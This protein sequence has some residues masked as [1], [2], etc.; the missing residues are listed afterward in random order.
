[1]V[2]SAVYEREGSRAN[3]VTKRGPTTMGKQ[4]DFA[5]DL[6]NGDVVFAKMVGYPWWPGVVESERSLPADIREARPEDD[7]ENLFAV[8]F[9]GDKSYAWLPRSAITL[10]DPN[11]P[12]SAS[13]AFK[14]TKKNS[15]VRFLSGVKEAMKLWHDRKNSRGILRSSSLQSPPLPARKL[16]ECSSQFNDEHAQ[17]KSRESVNRRS[18]DVDALPV[19]RRKD[20]RTP[21]PLT[22]DRREGRLCSGI[23]S[24]VNHGETVRQPQPLQQGH[25]YSF[26]A[27]PK[28]SVR[29]AESGEVPGLRTTRRLSSNSVVDEVFSNLEV[30]GSLKV[31]AD[32]S[33][34][35]TMKFSTKRNFDNAERNSA[36]STCRTKRRIV[37]E[38]VKEPLTIKQELAVPNGET[39][40]S[41]INDLCSFHNCLFGVKAEISEISNVSDHQRKTPVPSA[42]FEEEEVVAL[43]VLVNFR[44]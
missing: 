5:E 23:S 43:S 42:A 27:S 24:V 14:S 17:I 44:H 41:Q 40:M 1:M 3:S 26:R 29:A 31:D 18:V 10:F 35:S 36:D 32:T 22:M 20:K 28:I 11:H 30:R 13:K 16:Q 9:L 37:A 33:T 21:A 39:Q 34:A 15:K 12:K 19:T 38:M 4:E 8:R 2:A 25:G 7:A 6:Y